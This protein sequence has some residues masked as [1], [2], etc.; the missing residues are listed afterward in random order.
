MSEDDGLRT[1]I[2]QLLVQALAGG[3]YDLDA[4]RRRVLSG[5][6]FDQIGIDSLDLTAFVLH[7][8]D[9]FKIQVRLEDYAT[10][11]TLEAVESYVRNNT[12]ARV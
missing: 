2:L 11:S 6:R 4:V 8:Q 12:S 10:M 7:L 1:E 5:D 9:Y 3:D